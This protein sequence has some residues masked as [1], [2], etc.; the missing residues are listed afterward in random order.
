M[1]RA[2][3]YSVSTRVDPEKL[4][5][6]Q[7]ISFKYSRGLRASE[8]RTVI[9]QKVVP[10]LT[11]E[12]ADHVTTCLEDVRGNGEAVRK[13]YYVSKTSAV[14][15]EAG[16]ALSNADL[17]DLSLAQAAHRGKAAGRLAQWPWWRERQRQM[18]EEGAR[19]QRT[20]HHAQ[21]DPRRQETLP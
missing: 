4:K 18:E 3:Q 15:Y 14:S 10:E 11:E 21:P 7:V 20:P 5:P 9:V 19:R 2:R 17:G 16:E 1:E 6:G 12:G 8:R 13:N